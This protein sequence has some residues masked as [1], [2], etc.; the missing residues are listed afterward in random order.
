MLRRL[1]GSRIVFWTLMVSLA[2]LYGAPLGWMVMS[3][4]KTNREI[5]RTPLALPETIDFGVWVEAWNIGNLGRYM[6]NSVVVTSA[7][8]LGIIVMAALAAYAFSRFEFAGSKVL[9]AMFALGLLM[10]L[11]SYF[12]AQNALFEFLHIKNTRV[13][14]IIPYIGM[15]LPLAV[16]LLKAY[17]DGIPRGLFDA[18]RVDGA[19]DLRM[20][21]VIVMPLLRPGIATV[22]IFS[23]LS[24]WNEFLLAFLYVT[25]DNLK[26]IPTGLL[27]FTS[28]Y[29]TNYQLLFSAL[30]IV[31]IPM[32]VVYIAFH[33]QIVAG[34]TEGSLK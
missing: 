18:A 12:I 9:L 11:Q 22:A 16:Y 3:S 20:F 7:S 4:F 5:F 23:A 17:L 33:R 13:A 30:T 32:V 19:G 28:R 6:V 1:A 2:V 14:L 29:M 27:A 15:G 10:P 31:T 26:T 34:I 21:G 24:A 8:V 25:N